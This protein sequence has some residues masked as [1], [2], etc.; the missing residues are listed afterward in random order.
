VK[1]AMPLQV[2][3]SPRGSWMVAG[4]IL[5]AAL[6]LAS[7]LLLQDRFEIVQVANSVWRLDR[8]TGQVII[9][10]Y[11]LSGSDAAGQTWCYFPDTEPQRTA[12]LA[13]NPDRPLGAVP[14]QSKL[15]DPDAPT[16]AAG[17]TPPVTGPDFSKGAVPV[18]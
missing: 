2:G 3:T 17:A 6:L 11:G 10:S 16:S 4:S 1:P 5:I 13:A 14:A 18:R 15:N 7:S 8:L 9:C 12:P